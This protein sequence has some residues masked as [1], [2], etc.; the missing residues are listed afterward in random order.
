[1]GLGARRHQT[2]EG[3]GGQ[4]LGIFTSVTVDAAWGAASRP[5]EAYARIHV[6]DVVGESV[7]KFGNPAVGLW[8]GV[9]SFELTYAQ[10]RNVKVF[11]GAAAQKS[12]NFGIWCGFTDLGENIRVEKQS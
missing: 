10:H 5:F 1:M 3:G 8:V 2:F 6:D 4:G 12:N 9:E 7:E 11:I